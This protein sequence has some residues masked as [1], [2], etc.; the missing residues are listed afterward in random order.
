MSER[1]GFQS[2][3]AFCEWVINL[4]VRFG[5]DLGTAY[6]CAAVLADDPALAWLDTPEGARI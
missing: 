6:K 5:G 3:Q 4:I 1:L 2:V